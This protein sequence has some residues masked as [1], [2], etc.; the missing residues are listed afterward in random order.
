MTT[1]VREI[2]QMYEKDLIGLAG[3]L[4]E[5]YAGEIDDDPLDEFFDR[6]LDVKRIQSLGDK[7]W[8]TIGFELCLAWGGPGVW[9]D[10]G[11]YVITVAW[12]GDKVEYK[13][14]DERG[15]RAID[16]IH[17]RLMEIYG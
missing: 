15:R 10:T 11:N 16:E 8:E 14:M 12:W 3:K 1:D 4:E 13:V 17:E 9:L 7:G 5:Y 2:A 6:V